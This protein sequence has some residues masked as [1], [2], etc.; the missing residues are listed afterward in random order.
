M[1]GHCHLTA[2]QVETLERTGK[3]KTGTEK[4]PRVDTTWNTTWCTWCVLSVCG[5][6][7]QPNTSSALYIKLTRVTAPRLRLVADRLEPRS[8]VATAILHV[9]LG[10]V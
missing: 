10:F 6:P 5:T 4:S 1:M 9:A 3:K 2:V 8:A 7:T